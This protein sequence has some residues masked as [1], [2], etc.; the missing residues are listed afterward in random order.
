[1]V[2]R[3]GG[4]RVWRVREL[5]YGGSTCLTNAL[6]T[7]STRTDPAVRRLAVRPTP[8]VAEPHLPERDAKARWSVPGTS[9]ADT[10][11]PDAPG[12]RDLALDRWGRDR[13][14]P[15]G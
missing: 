7:C 12:S 11:V 1:M 8:H 15:V 5:R 2:I 3:T 4:L 14:G 6:N 13:R 9:E 10:A